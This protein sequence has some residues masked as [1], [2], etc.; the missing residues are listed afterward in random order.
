MLTDTPCPRQELAKCDGHIR[1]AICANNASQK[2]IH[3]ARCLSA[4][5][6]KQGCPKTRYGE[7]ELLSELTVRQQLSPAV[8]CTSRILNIGIK[9]KSFDSTEYSNQAVTT[10]KRYLF[11][12]THAADA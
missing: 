5:H 8:E 9:H 12:F 1:T 4:K 10:V 11:F 2:N 7:D 6:L 3:N